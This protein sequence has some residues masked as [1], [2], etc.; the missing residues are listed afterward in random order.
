V[1]L[2]WDRN[3]SGLAEIVLHHVSGAGA[4]VP[5]W[6]VNGL[7]VPGNPQSILPEI[8]EDGYGGAIAVWKRSDGTV[9]ALRIGANGPVAVAIALVSAEAEVG[10]VRLVWFAAEA[11]SLA[12]RV[13]R[14]TET[15]EWQ[16]LASV[17]PDGV[18]RIEYEDRDVMPG[19]RYAYRLAYSEDGAERAT[20][21]TWVTVPRL[22]LALRGFQPNPSIGTPQVALVL[23]ESAPASLE[24]FDVV[25]RRVASRAV[26]ALGPGRH[27]IPLDAGARL[28][29]GVYAIRLVQGE[30]VLH[31]RGVVTR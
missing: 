16:T 27:V 11:A 24:V 6:P 22:E 1:Y 5:G 17:T 9:R 23:A 20:E 25:G 26:G 28:T 18:G 14:R 30:R 29:P 2:A 19:T 7:V 21:E 15:G 3:T 10:R 8:T 12:A 13:E 31:A 4:V